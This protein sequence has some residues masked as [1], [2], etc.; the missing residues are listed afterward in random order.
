VSLTWVTILDWTALNINMDEQDLSRI[1]C[2]KYL[3]YI[4]KTVEK[5][6]VNLFLLIVMC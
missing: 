1:L 4:F 3:T 2:S 5:C 6:P